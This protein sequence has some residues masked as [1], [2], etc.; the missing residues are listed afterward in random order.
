MN[1]YCVMF[2]SQT[3]R[4]TVKRAGNGQ[5][6]IKDV[7]WTAAAQQ[8]LPITGNSVDPDQTPQYAASDQGL[9][10]LPCIQE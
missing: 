6:Q 9:H 8:V 10:C 5:R 2:Y 3:G 1:C 7:S 4:A